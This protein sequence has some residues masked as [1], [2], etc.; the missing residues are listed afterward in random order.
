MLS[1]PDIN[2]KAEYL[3]GALTE[4]DVEVLRS[5]LE[6]DIHKL[7][8]VPNLADK[9]F[10]ANASGVAMRYKLLGLEQLTSVKEQWFKEGLRARL[11]LIAHF[12][13]VRGAPKLDADQVRITLTR[14]LP[15]NLLELAEVVQTAH[16]AQAASLRTRVAMLHQADGWTNEQ[17]EEEAKQ[18]ALEQ[19]V[20]VEDPLQI[21]DPA[22]GDMEREE[23]DENG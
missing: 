19:G 16:N 9:D 4:A 7:S 14:A 6:T 17:I 22:L 23:E 1:L 2:A 18:L 10:A 12:M 21:R 11:R 20:D 8:M 3:Q 5:A 15:A 13:A